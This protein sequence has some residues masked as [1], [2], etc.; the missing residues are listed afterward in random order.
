MPLENRKHDY[1]LSQHN[2]E[3]FVEVIENCLQG[4]PVIFKAGEPEMRPYSKR[5]FAF[6]PF[7]QDKGP[8]YFGTSIRFDQDELDEEARAFVRAVAGELIAMDDAARAIPCE[9]DENEELF[10]VEIDPAE[11]LVQFNYSSTLWNTE[12][13][14]HYHFDDEGE[15][16]C[17]GMPDW[18]NP[19]QYIT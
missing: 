17:L 8:Y 7:D 1:R 19:G 2:A 10:E 6:E 5:T 11:G 9:H 3:F 14:V 15:W 12:W 18:R 4:V 13:A 16:K